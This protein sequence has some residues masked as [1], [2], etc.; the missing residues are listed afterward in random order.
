[1]DEGRLPLKKYQEY[2][3]WKATQTISSV[4]SK[5]NRKYRSREPKHIFGEKFVR[6]V[7]NSV[8]EGKVTLSKASKYL[9]GLSL[10]DM[11]QLG[12]YLIGN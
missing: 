9:D 6:A 10:K 11:H 7:F 2:K 8:Y 3:R 5:G 12:E 4:G 1:M